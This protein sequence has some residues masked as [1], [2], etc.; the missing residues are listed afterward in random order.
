MPTFTHLSADDQAEWAAYPVGTQAFAVDIASLVLWAATARMFGQCAEIARPVLCPRYG[1][2]EWVGG[3]P[4]WVP[5][6]LGDGSWINMPA[7]TICGGINPTRAKLRGPV[8]SIVS[9]SVEGAVVAPASYRLDEGEYLIRTDGL[10]W[11][12]WQNIAL[13]GT[14]A[15]AFVVNYLRGATVPDVVLAAAGTY[16]LE[17]ARSVSPGTTACRLPSRASSITRQGVSV[18]LVDPIQLLD[19]GLTGIPEVDQVILAINPRRYLAAPRVLAPGETA[20]LVGA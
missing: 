2:D 8:A 20:P 17:I 14:D 16:A 6:D 10:T 9:V 3:T 7:A 1:S 12:L 5:I 19:K 11:P 18:E 4:P 15:T 13:P